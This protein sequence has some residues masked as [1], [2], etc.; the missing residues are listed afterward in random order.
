MYEE[1]TAVPAGTT[2]V[3]CWNSEGMLIR[4][5]AGDRWD[6]GVR[7]YDREL[8]G[9]VGACSFRRI[10]SSTAV[11]LAAPVRA[12]DRTVAVGVNAV[13]LLLWAAALSRNGIACSFFSFS[14]IRRTRFTIHRMTIPTRIRAPT[15]PPMAPASLGVS[16]VELDASV[17]DD[18]LGDAPTGIDALEEVAGCDE[19]YRI[20][21]RKKDVVPV[22]VSLRV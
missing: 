6:L 8:E 2:V 21:R 18:E 14:S 15:P 5:A 3:A 1:A 10:F 13:W 16:F 4:L 19:L 17:V 22:T 20:P 9:A 7:A 11:E 12:T